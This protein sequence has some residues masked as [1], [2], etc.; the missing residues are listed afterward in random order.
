MG[1]S[2]VLLAVLAT[3]TL[4]LVGCGSGPSQVTSAAIVGDRSVPLAE[5]Q[6]EI[7]WLI[8][9]SPEAKEAKQQRKL[10]LTARE[11][12]ANR[13]KHELMAVAAQRMGLRAD[14]AQVDAQIERFGGVDAVATQIPTE[15]SRVREFFTDRVLA[16]QVGAQAVGNL[17]VTA[18][19][20]VITAEA[21][22]S[23]A[24]D[25]AIELGRKVAADP[26]RA[27]QLIAESGNEPA[28]RTWTLPQTFGEEAN[29]ELVISPLFGAK[30]GTV[31][32]I[33]PSS[34]AAGWMVALVTDRRTAPLPDAGQ[35]VPSQALSFIGWRQLQPLAEELGIRVNP[36][37]GVWDEAGMKLAPNTDE[38][39]GFQFPARD[40]RPSKP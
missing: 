35:G 36:R 19:S 37:Y 13:I 3:S 39:T 24:K 22:G 15:P 26:A 1:R 17:A 9:H 8:D 5:V 7:Q 21:P 40:V 6:Q 11:V 25:K 20:T 33:Q 32:V 10:D 18:V 4:L 12:V 31:L 34:Q 16:E 29:A 23:T 28:N 27:A 38:L 30:P 2:K 14:P